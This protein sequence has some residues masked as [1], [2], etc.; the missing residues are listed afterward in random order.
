MQPHATSRQPSVWCAISGHGYG[1]AAQIVPVLNELAR[2]VPGLVARLRT[3]VPAA[4]FRDRLATPWRLDPAE[5]DIGCVQRGPLQID[6]PATWEAYR[7]FHADWD[8]RVRDEADAIRAA[9]PRLV[10][11]DVPH[12]AIAAAHEAGVRALALSNL[13][14]DLVLEPLQ[15]PRDAI[16]QAVVDAI[17]AAYGRADAMLHLHPGPE[18]KA[19]AKVVRVAAVRQ[20]IQGDRA[21]LMRALDVPSETKVVLIGFGGVPLAT[22]PWGAVEQLPGY[23]F[24]H[25]SP[26]PAGCRRVTSHA[27]V[28][29]SFPALLASVDAVM[30]KPGYSTIVEAVAHGKPVL[31]VRRHIFADEPALVTYLHRYGRGRELSADAFTKGRWG[32]A[33]EALFQVPVPPEPPPAA[34]GARDAAQFLA[35]YFG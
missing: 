10:L 13:S 32:D 24:I 12:L 23:H 15:D 29:L 31:Y 8:S 22:L 16:H 6:V 2:L 18:M 3:A 34:T 19:F 9:R 4:F 17:R 30:T 33:L 5:Q 35:R 21:A 1:H 11:A 27:E 26:V 20:D 14:W 28:P 7:R 25:T